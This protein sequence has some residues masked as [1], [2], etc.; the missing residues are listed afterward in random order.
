VGAIHLPALL[1]AAHDQG[2]A[3]PPVQRAL[4]VL[5][6]SLPD[7]D[8][9]RIVVVTRAGDGRLLQRAIW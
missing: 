3:P 1:R 2:E 8:L 6:G 7:F 9:E 4:Q 5:A